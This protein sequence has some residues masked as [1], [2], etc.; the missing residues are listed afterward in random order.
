LSA[1]MLD[2]YSD[3]ITKNPIYEVTNGAYPWWNLQYASS[4]GKDELI[5]LGCLRSLFSE[6]VL[7]NISTLFIVMEEMKFHT[8]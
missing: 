6:L 7:W 2:A 8:I 4:H 1:S 3:N 5:I